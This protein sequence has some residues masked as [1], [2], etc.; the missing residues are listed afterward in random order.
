M[1]FEV[2]LI[3]MVINGLSTC[4]VDKIDR[5]PK[6]IDFFIFWHFFK[7]VL[8]SRYGFERSFERSVVVDLV[9]DFFGCFA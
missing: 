3:H 6:H 2:L 4:F 7:K 9:D 5:C 8:D 1:P